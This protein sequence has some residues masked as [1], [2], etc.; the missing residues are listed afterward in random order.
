MDSERIAPAQALAFARQI[1]SG[2]AHAHEQGVV[3]RDIKPANIM[4]TDEIGAGER[5]RILDF[6]LAR[7]RGNVGRDATQTNLVVGTPNYMAPEQTVPRRGDRRAHRHL[8]ASASCCSRWSSASDLQRR[9]HDAAARD[10]PRGADPPPR[11]SRARRHRA[12]GRPAGADRQGDGEEPVGA[13]S[14]RHRACRRDRRSD[15]GQGGPRP[16]QDITTINLVARGTDPTVV[17]PSVGGDTSRVRIGDRSCPKRSRLAARPRGRV[18]RRCGDGGLPDPPQLGG[19][20]TDQDCR[21]QRYRQRE[22]ARQPGARDHPRREH[23]DGGYARRGLSRRAVLFGATES[24]HYEADAATAEAED[25]AA[26]R[27]RVRDSVSGSAGAVGSAGPESRSRAWS[28]IPIQRRAPPRR[29]STKTTTHRR[30]RRRSKREPRSRII[31]PRPFRRRSADQGGQ[32]R[33]RA[34]EPARAVEEVA[35]ELVHPVPPGKPLLRPAVVVGRDGPLQCRD[36]EAPRYKQNAT[37][38]R[39]VIKM[40]GSSKTRSK[41]TSF[42]R[43]TITHPARAYLQA[44]ARNDENSVVRQQAKALIRGSARVRAAADART[45]ANGP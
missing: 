36:R 2:L 37:I 15:R 42:L 28:R 34:R 25:A 14:E 1:A 29:R 23:R 30:R 12:S 21:R 19:R 18:R 7:L 33:P 27:R 22:R 39:N 35:A 6:G 31:S 16:S 9:G 11:R 45:R 20:A 4:I 13:I 43:Y 5:M 44:A 10:A 8:R 26:A 3:H 17:A 24:M 41:A 40:L 38:N 32:A